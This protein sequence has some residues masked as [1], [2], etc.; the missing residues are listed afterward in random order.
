MG[1]DSDSCG[2]SCD[3]QKTYKSRSVIDSDSESDSD[4]PTNK[5]PPRSREAK[6]KGKGV[7]HKADKHLINYWYP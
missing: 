5:N 3:Q 4:S 7:L 2:E 1:S 6:N